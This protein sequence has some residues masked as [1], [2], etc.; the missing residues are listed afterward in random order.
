MAT[1]IR[2]RTIRD[3]PE[4]TWDCA[5]SGIWCRRC[6][7]WKGDNECDYLTSRR[8]HPESRSTLN[9]PVCELP[10]FADFFDQSGHAY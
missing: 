1:I 9:T 5:K 2:F 8:S 6:R 10:G 3:T 7:R 4:F